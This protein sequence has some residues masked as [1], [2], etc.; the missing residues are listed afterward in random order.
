MKTEYV[1]KFDPVNCPRC[2]SEFICKPN[3]IS[4]CDCMKIRLSPEEQNFISAQFAT[5]VCNTCLKELK[6]EYFKHYQNTKAHNVEV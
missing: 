6:F 5:C 1:I 4:N 3:H 2:K